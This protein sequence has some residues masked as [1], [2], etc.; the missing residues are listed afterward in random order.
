M[1]YPLLK[2]TVARAATLAACFQ[3]NLA[4]PQFGGPLGG[5]ARYPVIYEKHKVIDYSDRMARL[6][7]RTGVPG[8]ALRATA[9]L[10]QRYPQSP[11]Y[12]GLGLSTIGC[13]TPPPSMRTS[14]VI[15]Q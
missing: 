8:P 6:E 4:I 10:P 12:G 5:F 15:P 3:H 9:R 7:T 13:D 2:E 1:R 11:R 14:G